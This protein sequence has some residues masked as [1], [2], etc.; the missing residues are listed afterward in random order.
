[1]SSDAADRGGFC[2]ECGAFAPE[3]PAS[4]ACAACGR[5]MLKR[6]ARKRLELGRVDGENESR[7]AAAPPDVQEALRDPKNVFSTKYVLL[8]RIGSGGMGFVWKAWEIPLSRYVA[9]KFLKAPSPDDVVRF[10]REARLAAA[11]DHPN[12]IPVYDLGRS[13]GQYYLSM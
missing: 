12:I 5:P 11:L 6:E 3:V 8:R 9:I 1:M 13:E 10:E 2:L 7:A 4:G